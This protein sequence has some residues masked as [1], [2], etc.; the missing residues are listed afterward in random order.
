MR[1]YS[2][3]PTVITHW[4]LGATTYWRCIWPVTW[5]LYRKIEQFRPLWTDE[6]DQVLEEY[7]QKKIPDFPGLE[8]TRSEWENY[9]GEQDG[10]NRRRS[11]ADT[12]EDGDQFELDQREWD[13]R[14]HL[15]ERFRWICTQPNSEAIFNSLSNLNV[16][17]N[18]R[19][20][21]PLR[22]EPA[23]P[24]KKK[25]PKNNRRRARLNPNPPVGSWE[26]STW[27]LSN[28]TTTWEPFLPV[29]VRDQ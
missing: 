21:P 28:P 18:R 17:A 16:E 5:T 25:G 19:P 13:E 20:P 1:V 12:V 3:H 10:R 29:W 9:F 8:Q 11:S 7:Y 26:P 27:I 22:Q 23:G 15:L 6:V 2:G 14:D 4:H 24:K